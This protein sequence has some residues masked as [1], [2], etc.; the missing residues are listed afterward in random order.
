MFKLISRSATILA[1]A[2]LCLA[3]SPAWADQEKEPDAT[4]RTITTIKPLAGTINP[5]ASVYFYL[6]LYMGGTISDRLMAKC[7]EEYPK[8]QGAGA[9]LILCCINKRTDDALKDYEMNHCTMP[10]VALDQAA[11]LPGYVPSITSPY[12]L[13][14]NRQGKL[15]ASDDPEALEHWARLANA[16]PKATPKGS[17]LSKLKKSKLLR[18]KPA[19]NSRYFI[20]I[21]GSPQWAAVMD[22]AERYWREQEQLRKARTDVIICCWDLEE[23]DVTNTFLNASNNFPAI[24]RKEARRLPGF[25]ESVGFSI[26]LVDAKGNCIVRKIQT[27]YLEDWQKLISDWEQKKGASATKG[28]P[29]PSCDAPHAV[30]LMR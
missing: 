7:R 16:K 25:D 28:K 10:L 6:R 23:D 24:D 14:V 21:S 11:K 2:C 12:L 20:Y 29:R 5:D 26:T 3:L 1:A 27:F 8:I 4:A 9:E 17:V 15:L 18:G 19:K 22:G 30:S 13:V